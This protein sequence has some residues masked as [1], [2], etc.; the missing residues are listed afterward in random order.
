MVLEMLFPR[1]LNESR[2]ETQFDHQ[3]YRDTIELSEPSI[4]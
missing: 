2:Q 3:A 1:D 4:A